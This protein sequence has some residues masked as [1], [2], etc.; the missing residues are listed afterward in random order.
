MNDDD[1]SAGYIGEKLNVYGQPTLDK[2][3]EL[4]NGVIKEVIKIWGGGV[5]Y[6]RNNN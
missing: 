1:E 6:E 5:N 2:L 3:A 4:I